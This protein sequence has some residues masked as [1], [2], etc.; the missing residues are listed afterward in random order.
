M[1]KIVMEKR[2]PLL[3]IHTITAGDLGAA[4]GD[5]DETSTSSAGLNTNTDNNNIRPERATKLFTSIHNCNSNN[6][7]ASDHSGDDA[8]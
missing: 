1:I 3:M 6:N 7:D 5:H 2:W 4:G 8:V